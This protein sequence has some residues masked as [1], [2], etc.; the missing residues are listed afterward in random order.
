MELYERSQ[1]DPERCGI[2][3]PGKKS[4]ILL[5]LINLNDSPTTLVR[6]GIFFEP[7]ASKYLIEHGYHPEYPEEKPFAVCLTHDIDEVYTSLIKKKDKAEHHFRRGSFK[8]VMDSLSQMRSKKY[9]FM[10]FQ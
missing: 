3:L 8:G 5:F 2:F 7:R 6:T 1:K 9:S 4:I 10:E